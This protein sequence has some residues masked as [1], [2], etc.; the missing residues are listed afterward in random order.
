VP[1]LRVFAGPNGSGKSTLIDW[2]KP[3]WIGIYVN[4]DVLERTIKEQGSFDLATYGLGDDSQE[5]FDRLRASVRDSG[6][7]G[8]TADVLAAQLSLVGNEIR[9]P[10]DKMNSYI[11]AAFIDFVR[12]ELLA[13]SKDFTFE[14]VMSHAS[15]VAFMVEAQA[16]GY[17]TYLYFISTEMVEINIDRVSQR[18]ALGGHPVPESRIRDRYEKSIALLPLACDASN[19]AFIFDNSG[20]KQLLIAEITDGQELTVHQSLVPAWVTRTTLWQEFQ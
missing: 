1:R 10:S 19:R 13:A 14:T 3:E 11:A 2:L 18:V 4:A 7:L 6:R 20:P 17:R 16:R 15:K 8:D 12:E 5:R 9:F